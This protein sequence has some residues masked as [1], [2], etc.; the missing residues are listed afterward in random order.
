MGC[1]SHNGM[2]CSKLSDAIHP[3]L[4]GI[5]PTDDDIKDSMEPLKALMHNLEIMLSILLHY[6]QCH[7]DASMV[8]KNKYFEL[9]RDQI[10]QDFIVQIKTCLNSRNEWSNP[11]MVPTAM[12]KAE[13]MKHTNHEFSESKN[14]PVVEYLSGCI[15][16]IP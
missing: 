1:G 13:F 12:D 4:I 14:Q 11:F 16:Y 7:C 9:D 5:N 6:K 2:V 10:P 8:Y 15:Q 3:R